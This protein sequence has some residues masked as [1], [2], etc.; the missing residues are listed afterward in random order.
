MGRFCIGTMDTKHGWEVQSVPSAISLHITYWF[1]S[2]ENQ[3]K[4]LGKVPSFYKLFK[5]HGQSPEKMSE[6]TK[7]QFKAYLEEQFDD[8]VVECT[9]QNLTGNLNN[10]ALQLSARVVVD[11]VKYDIAETISVTGELYKLLDQERLKK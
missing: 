2:R 10:Y 8:V 11:G 3:G 1:E 5:D 7:T 9:R 4:V 6:E